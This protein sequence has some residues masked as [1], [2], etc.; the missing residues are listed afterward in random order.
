MPIGKVLFTVFHFVCLFVFTVTDFA[1][2]DKAS[3]I[4]FCTAVHQRPRHGISHFGELCSSRS[5]KSDE[6]SSA[7]TEL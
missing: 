3:V 2:K 7:C 5:P 4:K 6:S 1:A